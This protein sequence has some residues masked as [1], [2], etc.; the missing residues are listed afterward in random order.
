MELGVGCM[1]TYA[2]L[3]ADELVI[4]RKEDDMLMTP[5]LASG[6]N[7]GKVTDEWIT[8][9]RRTYRCMWCWPRTTRVRLPEVQCE[10][11]V[12]ASPMV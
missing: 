9:A 5:K 2:A 4:E 3:E 8:R 12:D 7:H 11:G 1:M 6:V 10:I